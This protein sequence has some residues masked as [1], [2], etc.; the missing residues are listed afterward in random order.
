MRRRPL[1]TQFC[2]NDPDMV[3]AAARHVEAHTDYV[4]INFGCPQRIARRGRYGAFLMDDLDGVERMVRR[5]QCMQPHDHR[6]SC[7][8]TACWT[9]AGRGRCR[10]CVR[11]AATARIA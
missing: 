4:D 9:T 8:M 10:V 5:S 1:F 3:V 2:G 11:V 6:S 7:H